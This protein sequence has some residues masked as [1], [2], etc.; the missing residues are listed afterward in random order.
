VTVL[1][2]SA[3]RDWENGYR[4]YRV[5]QRPGRLD[6]QLEGQIAAV[7]ASLRRRVGS[8]F[9]TA[10]LAAEYLDAERWVLDL[11]DDQATGTGWPETVML[12]C[13]AAFFL[14]SRS[15]LDYEP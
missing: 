10:E 15:A 14:Y 12:A 8:T 7:T 5:E 6:A 13:D 3:R 4:R 1:V 11:G 9:T 2:E